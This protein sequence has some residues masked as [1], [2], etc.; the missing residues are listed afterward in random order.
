MDEGR[1][2]FTQSRSTELQLH[3]T[4]SYSVPRGGRI[5]LCLK[6]YEQALQHMQNPNHKNECTEYYLNS[7]RASNG[8]Y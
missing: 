6:V 4:L 2:V 8:Q 5:C 3:A 7:A 1:R